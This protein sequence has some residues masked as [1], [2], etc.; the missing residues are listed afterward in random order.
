MT[1]D[2]SDFTSLY[3]SFFVKWYQQLNLSHRVDE[4]TNFDDIWKVLKAV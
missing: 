4:M 3:L 2:Y 1:L